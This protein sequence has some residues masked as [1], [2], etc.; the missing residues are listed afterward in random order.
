MLGLVVAN[1]V[2][3]EPFDDGLGLHCDTIIRQGSLFKGALND[4]LALWDE[5]GPRGR[6]LTKPR[7]VKGAETT[8]SPS[9][10]LSV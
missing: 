1:N 8:A 7:P 3:G 5:M 6:P 10:D 4:V 2:F 9:A